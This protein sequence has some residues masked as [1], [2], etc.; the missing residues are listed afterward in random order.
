MKKFIMFIFM[1]GLLFSIVSFPAHAVDY[2]FTIL[3][4]YP[5]PNNITNYYAFSGTKFCRILPDK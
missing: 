2:T 1:M 5:A 4:D 3:P